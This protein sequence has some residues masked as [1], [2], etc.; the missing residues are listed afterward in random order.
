M[1]NKLKDSLNFVME[2]FGPFVLLVGACL[3]TSLVGIPWALHHN[4]VNQ[5]HIERSYH[6][7]GTF[8]AGTNLLSVC[9]GEDLS[10]HKQYSFRD[11]KKEIY[12]DYGLNWSSFE[13]R[14]NRIIYKDPKGPYEVTPLGQTKTNSLVNSIFTK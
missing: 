2:E 10:K 9:E 5:E 11:N 1:K 14:G 7:I 6:Q 12:S 13:Y 4:K 8:Q 3:A